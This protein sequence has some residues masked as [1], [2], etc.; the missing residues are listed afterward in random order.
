[1]CKFLPFPGSFFLLVQA[2]QN[3]WLAN[4]LI[5]YTEQLSNYGIVLLSWLC[6]IPGHG[7]RILVE[8]G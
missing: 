8:A 5:S 1:M 7:R 6:S 2:R 3:V 4:T